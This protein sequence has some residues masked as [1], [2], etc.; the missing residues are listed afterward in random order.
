VILRK[1]KKWYVVER[2]VFLN[3]HPADVGAARIVKTGMGR[4]SKGPYGGVLWGWGRGIRGGFLNG[5]G[6]QTKVEG[7]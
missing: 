4:R 5:G 6:G 2:K 7:K 3:V 1:K